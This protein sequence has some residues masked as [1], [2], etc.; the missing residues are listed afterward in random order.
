MAG[1][2]AG[3]LN[4]YDYPG[5]GLHQELELLVKYGLTPLEA[6]QA[7]V[8]NSPRFLGKA[9]YGAIAKDKIADV[10]LLDENPLQNISNTQ[11]IY[12]VVTK[13]KLLDRKKLDQ[14]LGEVQSAASKT[15]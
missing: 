6:L 3:F 14:L 8:V 4:S 2:D 15:K 9:N 1:T 10:L 7:S 12:A 13:G 11:K 5:L